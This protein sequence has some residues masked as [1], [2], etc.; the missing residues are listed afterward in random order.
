MKKAFKVIAHVTD[1]S[2]MHRGTTVTAG[3]EQ[4]AQDKAYKILALTHEH[5]IEV[6]PVTVYSPNTE[7]TTDSYPYDGSEEEAEING[8]YYYA[9]RQ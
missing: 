9:Y 6:I 4:E 3:S 2:W 8:T 5:T 7:L 1:K